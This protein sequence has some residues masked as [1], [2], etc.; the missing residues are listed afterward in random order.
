MQLKVRQLEVEQGILTFRSWLQAEREEC[1]KE[2]D[3]DDEERKK[4]TNDCIVS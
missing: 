2:G 1:K 3:G 4:G